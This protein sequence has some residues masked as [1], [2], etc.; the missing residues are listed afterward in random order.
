LSHS[1]PDEDTWITEELLKE[2]SE[3]RGVAVE[4]LR[5]RRIWFGVRAA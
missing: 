1:P 2:E 4:V 3:A 5:Q